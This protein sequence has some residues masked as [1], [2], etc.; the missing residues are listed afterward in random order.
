MSLFGIRITYQADKR[1]FHHHVVKME[2]FYYYYF[3]CECLRYQRVVVHP[4]EPALR[5]R[6]PIQACSPI[7]LFL[8]NATRPHWWGVLVVLSDTS[9]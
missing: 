5:Q 3:Y 6:S 8:P 1:Q 2:L 4:H 9:P 7:I